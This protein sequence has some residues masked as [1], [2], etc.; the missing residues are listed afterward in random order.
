VTAQQALTTDP[1]TRQRQVLRISELRSHPARMLVMFGTP[2]AF[3]ITGL[4][5]VVAAGEHN[6]YTAVGDQAPVWI[7]VHTVQLLLILLMAVAIYWFTEGLTGPV[8]QSSRVALL[9]YLVF[10]SAFDSV[11]GLSNGLVAQY[12]R[13]LTVAEQAVLPGVS[14]ALSGGGFDQ[15]VPFAI[16][17]IASASWF[18]AVT[19]AAVA[20]HRAGA[21]P[22]ATIPLGL[23]GVIGAVDHALPF[24]T[25][26]MVLF[27]LAAYVLSRPRTT[28]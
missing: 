20:L 13:G 18:V 27:L 15:P 23:A 1:V 9:F 6:L 10:Y 14:D 8:A 21:P 24:G 12:G 2:T 26:A 4:L 17:L 16:A 11:V 3:L 22:S 7:G 25:I 5:H 28:R 19:A